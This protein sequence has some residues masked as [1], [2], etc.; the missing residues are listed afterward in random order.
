[1][2]LRILPFCIAV[3]VLLVGCGVMSPARPASALC[4]AFPAQA[5]LVLESSEAFVATRDGF[6]AG[7]QARLPRRGDSA[8]RFPLGDGLE[9]RV[10]EVGARGEGVIAE[11]AVAY[12]RAGGI[13]FWAATSLGM[14]EWLMLDAG[15]VRR[16]EAVAAW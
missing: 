6:E 8:I 16:D 14:E 5:G 2:P 13:S 9:A 4:R 15:A 11:H 10:R 7:R 3:I 1:M 12:L